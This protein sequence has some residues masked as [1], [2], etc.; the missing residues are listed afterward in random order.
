VKLHINPDVIPKQK[1][2][3]RI[4]FH[5]Q[6]DIEKHL[7]RLEGLYFVEKTDGSTPWVSPF[8]AV[9]KKK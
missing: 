2:H 9:P 6:E 4:P 5:I 1:Y 8:V 7:K 3:R